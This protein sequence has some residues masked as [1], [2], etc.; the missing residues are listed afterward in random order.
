MTADTL[1]VKRVKK[2]AGRTA[3]MHG[4]RYGGKCSPPADKTWR[5]GEPGSPACG[6]EA[7]R[8]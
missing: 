7:A 3:T 8:R 1:T 2:I 4:H 6:E 5:P